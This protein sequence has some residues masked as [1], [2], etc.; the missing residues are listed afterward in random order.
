MNA[1]YMKIINNN[2]GNGGYGI[3]PISMDAGDEH[4]LAESQTHYG[5]APVT[6]GN[7]YPTNVLVTLDQPNSNGAISVVNSPGVPY[8]KHIK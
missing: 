4:F 2:T 1:V 8:I 7:L 6:S 5:V 3:M